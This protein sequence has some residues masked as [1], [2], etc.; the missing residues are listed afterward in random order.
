[1]QKTQKR[2]DLIVI[3][4]GPGGLRAAIQ[5]AK[6]GRSVAIVEKDKA[7]GASVHTGTIPSKSLREAALQK[8]DFADAM[9]RM[10]QV[11][12]AESEVVAD[13]LARNG[14]EWFR[15]LASFEGPH[16][17]SVANGPRLS[18]D[19]FVIATGTRPIRHAEFPFRLKNVHD[20]DSI[21]RAPARPRNLL[22]V[23][24]G[25][26]GC[27]YA[28]IFSR[29]GSRVT[30]VDRRKELLRSVDPEVIEALRQAFG[31]AGLELSLGCELGA[32]SAAKES[33]KLDV[34]LNGKTRKF[35]AALVCMGRQP[36]TEGLA[37]DKIGLELDARGN[38]PVDRSN[39]RTKIAHIYAVG[40]VIGAPGLAASSAEQGRIAACRIFGQDCHGFPDSFPYGIYTIPEI[41]SVGL[42]EAEAREK[43]L[44]YVVGRAHFRE[45][46]RGLIA[47]DSNGFIKLI[48]QRETQKILGVHAIGMGATELVHIGQAALALGAPIDF[49]VDNVFNYPTFAEAY[50]VAA[51]HA[52]NQLKP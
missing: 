50:K 48:V 23:G 2:F 41:S 31:E 1:M 38:I 26:I 4:S 27:E 32:I 21:L 18:A 13:Q 47:G 35:D 15:G 16:E 34:K 37:L 14:V 20:S 3:G 7:G 40:D 33:A 45:I 11:R 51:L 5:A 46:A 29:L 8:C 22:V 9:A 10:R 17:I 44:P 30:L 36:N 25:V 49:L 6:L 43:A 12:R 24:A 42:L 19:H 52:K 39:F 28:S